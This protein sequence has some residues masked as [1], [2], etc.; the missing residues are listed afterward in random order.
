MRIEILGTVSV[1]P[2]RREQPIGANKVRALLATLALDPGRSVSAV[3]LADELWSGQ[4]LGN[5]HN[6]LQ[7]HAT[8]LR[9]ILDGPQRRPSGATVL[10]AVQGGY[11]L[12][13]PGSCVDAN[14][15]LGLAAQG[16]AALPADPRRSVRLLESA[17]RLW[18]GPALL[19]A[20][21]GLRCRAAA[22][23]YEERRLMVWENLALARLA[24]GDAGQATAEL[25]RLETEHPLHERF[26]ELLMIALYQSGRQGEALHA[27]HRIRERLDRELGLAP[28]APL[29]ERHMEILAQR[30]VLTLT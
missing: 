14:R 27:Y 28:G 25:R 13:V 29:R 26:C 22:A 12:D 10:R 17:L 20:G 1:Y 11:I 16:S 24:V 18:R 3:E 19:D 15:F 6:A 30:P 8:R 5:V 21:D 7:A 2:D 9:K 23:L 4:P